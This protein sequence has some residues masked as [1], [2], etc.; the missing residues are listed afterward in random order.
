MTGVCTRCGTTGTLARQDL[1]RPCYLPLWRAG[2]LPPLPAVRTYA[3]P[4]DCAHDGRPHRH[5]TR[6]AYV[7]D[8]CRCQPCTEASRVSQA[9]RRRLQAMAVWNPDSYDLVDGDLVRAHLRQLMA[10]GMGWKRV[11]AAAGV[12]ASTVYPILYGKWIHQ[13]EHPQHRPPRKQVTKAVADKLLAV[14]LDLADGRQI[15]ATGT[16]RRLQ[17]LAAIGLPQA[18]LARLIGWSP[19]NFS[20]LIHGRQQYTVKANADLV[21]R[22]YDQHW[23]G[24]PQAT[25]PRETAS[26]ERARRVASSHGWAPPMSWD[27]DSIDDRRARPCGVDRK[28]RAV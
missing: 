16:R 23:Q 27:D 19:G 2:T 6:V 10:A 20:D 28:G 15:D 11:A 21:A 24:P 13:P 4:T 7:W 22:I 25:T 14:T 8:K 5:G 1:C 3:E 9:E 12:G 18:Q 17:A 26:I